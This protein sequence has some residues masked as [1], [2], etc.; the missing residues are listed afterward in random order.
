M[1]A[2]LRSRAV[3]LP[4][5]TAALA[6]LVLL[7]AALLTLARLTGTL[8]GVELL[9]QVGLALLFLALLLVDLRAGLAIVVLELALGGASG[10]WTVLPGGASGRILLDGLC[11]AVAIGRLVPVAI[12]DRRA[13]GRY[14]LHALVL[15]LVLPGIW[16]TL[17]VLNGNVTS[18]VFGDGNGHIFF[19]FTLVVAAVALRGDLAWLRRWL[20]VACMGTA[21]MTAAIPLIDKL[22]RINGRDLAVFLFTTLGQGGNLSVIGDGSLRIYLGSGLYLVI[23]LILTAWEL[24]RGPRRVWPWLLLAVFGVEVLLT[25]TRGYW[26]AAALGVAVVMLLELGLRRSAAI[27]AAVTTVFLAAAL[28]GPAVGVDYPHALLVRMATIVSFGPDGS[29]DPAADQG[30]TSNGIKGYQAE[31]LFGEIVKHPILGSGFGSIAPNYPFGDTYSYEL[32]FLDLAYKTGLIGLAL[33]LSFPLR[34]IA[35]GIRVRK[36]RLR[37]PPGMDAREAAVPIAIVASLLVLGATNPY[38]T[39]AFGLAPIILCVAWLEPFD[40]LASGERRFAR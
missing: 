17:G 4:R 29:S 21:V 5:A 35:D 1:T 8:G 23:G 22:F 14:G 2:T 13:L 6:I 28:G 25:Y 39:A 18:D 3:R 19:A 20:L 7:D 15:A 33:F 32:A 31:V 11:F 37:G 12:R 26:V 34:L 27:G 38:L 9:A 16:M 40:A 30:E 36:G 24:L 10:H